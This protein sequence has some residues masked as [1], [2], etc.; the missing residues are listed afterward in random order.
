MYVSS[1]IG[2]LPHSSSGMSL[3]K[4]V[5]DSDASH[6]MSPNSLSLAS[7]SP[8]SSIHVMI[9][10]D[11]LMLLASV[12]FAI[13]PHLSL[14]NAYDL[15][16]QKLIGTGH[17][18]KGLY[19]L[20]ELKVS[21]VATGVDLSPLHLSSFSSSFYLWCDFDEEYISNKFYELLA[22]DGTTHQTSCVDTPEQND[23]AETKYRHIVKT[24]HSFLL[25]A[26]V[27][28]LFWG[29][30][31]LTTVGTDTLLSSTPEAPFSSMVPPAS[32]EIMELPLHQSINIPS[33]K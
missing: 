26:L 5:L 1:F 12:G 19:I 29:E 31:V 21:V 13:V 24:T 8:S 3:S 18:E 33:Y 30:V 9:V 15:Q 25:S 14:S 32:S 23:V 11:T 10:D 4:W 20:D 17:R 6:H 7:V 16:S 28:N 2:Q 22:L 27:P